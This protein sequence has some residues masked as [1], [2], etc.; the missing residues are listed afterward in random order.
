MCVRVQSVNSE[1]TVW[2]HNG[3]PRAGRHYRVPKAGTRFFNQ[4][5]PV[6]DDV[7]GHVIRFLGGPPFSRFTRILRFVCEP[8]CYF[9]KN[10]M[11]VTSSACIE[12]GIVVP[13][14]VPT[15]DISSFY[16]WEKNVLKCNSPTQNVH[17]SLNLTLMTWKNINITERESRYGTRS[18]R[19]ALW[20]P[21]HVLTITIW[22]SA[23]FP[24]CAAL[25]GWGQ[26]VSFTYLCAVM[27]KYE[28]ACYY[29]AIAVKQLAI[30]RYLLGSDG[31]LTT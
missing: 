19:C 29:S 5:G 1:C 18:S 10:H 22:V 17:L 24:R 14:W 31:M 15:H 16:L 25:V 28:I 13:R 6:P 21:E 23:A 3:I 27:M 8:V 4:S 7:K 20:I 2:K 30:T 9:E 11:C 12:K 26:R